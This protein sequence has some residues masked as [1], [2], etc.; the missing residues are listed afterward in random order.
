MVVQLTPVLCPPHYWLIER[1]ASHYQQWTCRRCAAAESHE[2]RPVASWGNRAKKPVAAASE[3]TIDSRER[4]GW[5][6]GS[7]I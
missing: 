6:T 5:T 7:V 1:T 2:D 3:T 4:P